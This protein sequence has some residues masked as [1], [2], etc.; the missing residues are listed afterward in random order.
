M[1][2]QASA[3][4]FRVRRCFNRIILMNIDCGNI[5]RTSGIHGIVCAENSQMAINRI[6]DAGAG[7]GGFSALYVF[8]KICDKALV[9]AA[10]TAGYAGS[11]AVYVQINGF[12]RIFASG[13]GVNFPYDEA[14][15]IG[16]SPNLSFCADQMNGTLRF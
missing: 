12:F 9:T 5:H 4:P 6:G 11:V 3:A 15:I 2:Q 14:G 8:N 1:I 13:S 16:K 7:Y 10:V